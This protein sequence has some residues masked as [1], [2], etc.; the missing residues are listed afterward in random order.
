M[1]YDAY[2]SLQMCE[3]DMESLLILMNYNKINNSF[4]FNSHLGI[5][6]QRIFFMIWPNSQTTFR[7][8]YDTRL[9]L[10]QLTI[11]M[12][13]MTIWNNCHN[14]NNIK[15]YPNQIA[16]PNNTNIYTTFFKYHQ[17]QN[18]NM[19]N[20]NCHN[21]ILPQQHQQTHR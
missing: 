7:A 8:I 13:Y 10:T 18:D 9:H 12:S 17:N 3:Y 5:Q 21:R 16:T 2:L 15:V 6:Y 20:N 11:E 19:I 14:N 1:L 4:K